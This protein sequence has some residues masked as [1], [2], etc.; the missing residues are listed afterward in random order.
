MGKI[1]PRG[2]SL[3]DLFILMLLDFSMDKRQ[4]D[5][6]QKFLCNEVNDLGTHF[7]EDSLYNGFDQRRIRRGRLREIGGRGL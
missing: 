1:R 6:P 2:K 4:N 3:G 7:F 5:G